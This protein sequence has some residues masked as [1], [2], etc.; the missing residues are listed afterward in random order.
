MRRLE[1]HGGAIH[2]VCSWHRLI[3]ALVLITVTINCGCSTRAMMPMSQ[4]QRDEIEGLVGKR[5]KFH[6]DT[7]VHEIKVTSVD[8]PY[9]EGSPYVEGYDELFGKSA[10]THKRTR[11]DLR[12]VNQ[13]EVTKVHAGRTIVLVVVIA[14]VVA[15]AF[16]AAIAAADPTITPDN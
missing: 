1:P 3:A 8:Y 13:I 11:I 7:A 15:L 6:T 2:G 4:V 16:A 10:A 12:T 9:I 14:S 5:V